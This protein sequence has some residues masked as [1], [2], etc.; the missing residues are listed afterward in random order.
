M[1]GFSLVPCV[2]FKLMLFR[3]LRRLCVSVG[4]R[5][6]GLPNYIAMV[7]GTLMR[8]HIRGILTSSGRTFLQLGPHTA[9]AF[10]QLAP[11]SFRAA[12]LF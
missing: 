2:L 3:Q 5:R 1:I 4:A 9:V 10:R 8:T 6:R 12:S 7:T 11:I